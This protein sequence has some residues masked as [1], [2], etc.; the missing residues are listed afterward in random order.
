V[1][2]L[3]FDFEYTKGLDQVRLDFFYKEAKRQRI[4]KAFSLYNL[5][6][7][8][9]ME[10]DE[11]RKVFAVL[12]EHLNPHRITYVPDKRETKT[13]WALLRSRRR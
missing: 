3:H 9:M 1:S 11:T 13:G 5:I 4:D 10:K 6:Q 2:E 8:M 12:K 7:T